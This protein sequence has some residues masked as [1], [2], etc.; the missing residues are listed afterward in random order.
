M[1]LGIGPSCFSNL[2]AMRFASRGAGCAHR[3]AIADG[4]SV[5]FANGSA[6]FLDRRR[7]ARGNARSRRFSEFWRHAFFALELPNNWNP[8]QILS[9]LV[10]DE[11]TEMLP[12]R[13][14]TS[15]VA[16]HFN[17]P[18]TEPPQVMLLAVCPA[19]GENW[20]WEYLSETILD[21]FERAKKRLVNFDHLRT[22]PALAHLLPALVAP[23][24]RDNLGPNLDLGR[25]KSDMPPT[26]EERRRL[27]HCKTSNEFKMP[28]SVLIW[29]RLEPQPRTN[30]LSVA[31]RCEVRDALWM[32]ARQW[33][34][35][36]FRAEDA[37]ACAF[38]KVQCDSVFAQKLSL[39]GAEPTNLLAR[40][41]A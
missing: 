3:R 21:T 7:D 11:W 30:D 4:Y 38:V 40:N 41:A 26:Q 13:E 35:G 18:D 39:R 33:Q 2:P 16:F 25:N 9:G 6:R 5:Q 23:L 12:A 28:S 1:P 32:L 24:E 34:M 31:L 10:F 27:F 14:T 22:N 8:T 36:E 17:Q 37:G 20:R 15:G 29:N 19:E